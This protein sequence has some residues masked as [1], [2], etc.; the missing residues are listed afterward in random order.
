MTFKEMK[1]LLLNYS[2]VTEKI[3]GIEKEIELAREEIRAI[4]ESVGA[5]L[6]G[7]PRGSAVSDPTYR[8]AQKIIDKFDK[9]VESLLEERERIMEGQQRLTDLL[10]QLDRDEYSVIKARYLEGTRW[11]YIPMKVY[12]SRAQCFNLH[13]RAI[14]KMIKAYGEE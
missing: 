2:A 1:G 8:K 3:Y 7:M 14:G 9:R 11:D 5:T 4:R 12:V 6:G 13:D 10:K